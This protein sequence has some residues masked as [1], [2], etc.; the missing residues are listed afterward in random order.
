MHPTPRGLPADDADPVTAPGCGQVDRPAGRG[1]V[2]V[3]LTTHTGSGGA[4]P[5]SVKTGQFRA[6]VPR[7]L[8]PQRPAGLFLHELPLTVDDTEG[9][10]GQQDSGQ[11][12]AD[13]GGQG[14]VPWAG[15]RG[16][17]PHQVDLA[18]TVRL[19]RGRGVPARHTLHVLKTDEHCLPIKPGQAVP[20][21]GVRCGGAVGLLEA[22]QQRA[23]QTRLALL[24]APV[25]LEPE[26]PAARAPSVLP[27][28]EATLLGQLH[29]RP[30]LLAENTVSRSIP[31]FLLAT[32][33]C[34]TRSFTCQTG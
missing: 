18:A 24:K 15:G 25:L 1:G 4:E 3:A 8:C 28:A 7:V 23:V 17:D 20:A 22:A 29:A 33:S 5:R 14:R 30:T 34:F 26:R 27:E 9:E 10:Q 13:H 11:C 32:V 19:V 12:A 16:R 2:P 21:D 31:E 6:L